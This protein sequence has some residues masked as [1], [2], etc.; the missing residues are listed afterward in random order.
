LAAAVTLALSVVVASVVWIGVGQSGTHSPAGAGRGGTL[1]FDQ[2]WARDLGGRIDTEPVLAGDLLLVE[3]TDPMSAEPTLRALDRAS[4][5]T[6]WTR[7]LP[8]RP[9]T[10]P[11]VSGSTVVLVLGDGERIGVDVGDGKVRWH[12][13]VA[14]TGFFDPPVPVRPVVDGPTVYLMEADGIIESVDAFSGAAHWQLQVGFPL[15]TPTLAAGVLYLTTTMLPLGPDSPGNVTALDATTGAVKWQ[16]H[17]DG[18]VTSRPAVSGSVVAVTTGGYDLTP[19]GSVLLLDVD[20]G[21]VRFRADLTGWLS[22]PATTEQLIVVASTSGQLEARDA[23]GQVRWRVDIGATQGPEPHPFPVLGAAPDL[24]VEGTLAIVTATDVVGVDATTGT[25]RWRASV[26]TPR[27]AAAP[28]KG[29][30]VAVTDSTGTLEIIDTADGR[31]LA[32]RSLLDDLNGV[33]IADG[34]VY[35]TDDWGTAEAFAL[36]PAAQVRNRLPVLCRA[37]DPPRFAGT[38]ELP[39]LGQTAR[40]RVQRVLRADADK[41]RAEYP[42][43]RRLEVQPRGGAVMDGALQDFVDDYWIVAQLRS[44]RDCPTSPQSWNGVPLRFIVTTR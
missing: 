6:R 23:T 38:Q 36:R 11:V 17:L 24:A 8:A 25:V 14:S 1:A 15:A 31:I 32:G 3:Q 27:L 21:V 5:R 19:D 18:P 7:A 4:G 37:A 30:A 34:R 12:A 33:A 39:R 29:R 41:I 40:S 35:E 22:D 42:G 9:A 20:T 13:Q 26:P 10:T 28:A 43:V 2:L 16:R 44:T